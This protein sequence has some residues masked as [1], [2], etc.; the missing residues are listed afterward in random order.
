LPNAHVDVPSLNPRLTFA[1]VDPCILQDSTGPTRTGDPPRRRDLVASS[2]VPCRPVWQGVSTDSLKFHLGPPSLTLQ[3][4]VGGPPLKWLYGRFWGVPPAGRAA[5][6]HLLSLWISHAVRA[7]CLD[8]G[9]T[10]VA[11]VA[12]LMF[13]A[14]PLRPSSRPS[15]SIEV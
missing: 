15:S 10:A 5:C 1:F 2:S 8:D 13:T 12:L 14:H 7:W 6:D 11:S 3:R 9:L 4:P